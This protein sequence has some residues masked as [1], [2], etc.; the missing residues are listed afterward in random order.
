[1]KGGWRPKHIEASTLKNYYAFGRD[2]FL[3][4]DIDTITHFC[5]SL[6]ELEHKLTEREELFL[7]LS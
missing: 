1:M 6:K 3:K 5:D 2:G 4:K 7:E